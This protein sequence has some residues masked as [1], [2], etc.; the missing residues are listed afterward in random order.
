[1]TCSARV[2]RPGNPA[3]A[4]EKRGRMVTGGRSLDR[5]LYGFLNSAVIHGAE[6]PLPCAIS[7]RMRATNLSPAPTAQHQQS[8]TPC[9]AR[10]IRGVSRRSFPQLTAERVPAERLR[11]AA[12]QATKPATSVPSLK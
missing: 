11:C 12:N 2:E 4:Q 10:K 3:M 6:P 9:D 1:A 7:E 8:N 5:L